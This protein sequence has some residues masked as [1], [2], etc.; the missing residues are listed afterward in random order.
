RGVAHRGERPRRRRLPRLDRTRGSGRGDLREPLRGDRACAGA[1]RG[2]FR[3]AAL[4]SRGGR[5]RPHHGARARGPRPYGGRRRVGDARGTGADDVARA[6]A[7]TSLIAKET[8]KTY[9]ISSSE[10][11]THPPVGRLA[12]SGARDATDARSARLP[13]VRRSRAR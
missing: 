5:D 3:A 4:G 6:A 2:G 9:G 1:G 10:T 11:A 8:L 13:V 7:E 12:P